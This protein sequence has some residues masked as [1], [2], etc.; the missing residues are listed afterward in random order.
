MRKRRILFRG[1]GHGGALRTV[2]VIY[3][4]LIQVRVYGHGGRIGS[5]IAVIR[6]AAALQN[7][8][9]D[10]NEYRVFHFFTIA[11]AIFFASKKKCRWVAAFR[12]SWL[13]NQKPPYELLSWKGPDW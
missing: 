4:G 13:S 9:A 6:A 8:C 5:R 3:I 1:I 7:S 12:V 11:G 10:Q 2:D